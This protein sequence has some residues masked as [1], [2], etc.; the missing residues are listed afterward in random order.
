MPLTMGNVEWPPPDCKRAAQHYAEWSA[1]YAGNPEALMGYY[2]NAPLLKNR[3]AQFA[4]GLVGMLARAWWGRPIAQGQPAVKIHVPLAAD[5]ATLSADL[6]FGSPPDIEL[7]DAGD[8]AGTRW[9]KIQEYGNLFATLT[10]AAEVCAAMGG[11]YLKASV[12][13][14]VVPVPFLSVSAPEYAVP[15]WTLG[16]LTSVIFWR[17]VHRDEDGKGSSV[18]RLLEQHEPGLVS[19]ALYEGTADKLGEPRD[20]RSLP[21]TQQFLTV[22]ADGQPSGQAGD[23]V[24]YLTGVDGL[25]ASYVPNMRPNRD[26]LGSALGRSDFSGAQGMMDAVDE[27]FSSLIRDVRL[28]KNRIIAPSHMLKSLGAGNGAAFDVEQEIF[29]SVDGMPDA[30][31]GASQLFQA[32]FVIRAA[33]HLAAARAFAAEVMKNAGY[34]AGELDDD[35]SGGQKT[36]TEVAN[37]GSRSVATRGRKINYWTPVLRWAAITLAQL[38]AFWFRSGIQLVDDPDIEFPDTVTV[39]PEKTARTVQ[40]LDAAGAVSVETMV[41]IV[42]PDWD[43]VA[44]SEEVARIRAETTASAPPDPSTLFGAPTDPAADPELQPGVPAID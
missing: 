36:A 2:S 20:L 39:D 3:P 5:L 31:A 33:D 30:T 22:G 19:Y 12:L 13:P 40:M 6:L 1:W 7:P 21:Q 17:E 43:D 27:T 16:W 4:G 26:W 14:S 23:G 10:E 15:S 34:D 32:Q 41:R 9:A 25:T 37:D 8:Q 29:T 24:S 38:D 18:W 11:V 28:G 35:A 42:H 44:V